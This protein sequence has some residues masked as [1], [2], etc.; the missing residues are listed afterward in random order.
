MTVEKLVSDLKSKTK[1][2]GPTNKF[3]LGGHISPAVGKQQK[4]RSTKPHAD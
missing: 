2:S 4:L 1:E 3:S